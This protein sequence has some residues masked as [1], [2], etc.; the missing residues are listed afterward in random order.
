[1]SVDG[2]Q[3]RAELLRKRRVWNGWLLLVASLLIPLLGLWA[4]WVG[5]TLRDS[6]PRTAWVLMPAGVTICVLRLY[7]YL[8]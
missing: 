2:A 3:A 7:F 4:S 1:M 6:A 5:F 8:A